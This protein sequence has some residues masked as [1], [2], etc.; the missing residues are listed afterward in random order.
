V[1]RENLSIDEANEEVKL[2]I[3]GIFAGM[4]ALSATSHVPVVFVG[5]C[6]I[7]G[8]VFSTG[9]TLVG[10]D[11]HIDPHDMALAGA[12][13]YALGHIHKAQQ[14]GPKMWYSGSTFHCNFGE[15]EIKSFIDVNVEKGSTEIVQVEIPS[16]PL[17]LHDMEFT[18]DGL[19]HTDLNAQ[20]DW[21]NA[22][23]R[24]RVHVTKELAEHVTEELVADTFPGAYSIKT[25]KIIVPE[26]RLRAGNITK[27][28]Q[29]RDK[30]AEWGKSVEKE[31]PPEVFEFAD[32]TEK[33][34][35]GQ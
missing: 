9:Q 14:V 27:A 20:V 11:I 29:L 23:L 30:V 18:L 4:G 15:T 25:E 10:Q 2:A 34:V 7:V 6:N 19:H 35:A 16:R 13:Y 31:I 26:N 1:G 8:A 5:H 17:S 12:D 22:E 3:N 21:R 32:E 33:A 24:V 28:K